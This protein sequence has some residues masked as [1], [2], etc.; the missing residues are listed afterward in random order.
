MTAYSRCSKTTSDG[1]YIL[2]LHSVNRKIMDFAIYLPKDLLRFD[3]DLRKWLA[4]DLERGQITV[5]L[6]VQHENINS[7]SNYILQLR[8]SKENWE[9]I[10]YELGYNP[11][12]AIDFS[13]VL[14]HF[15]PP[16]YFNQAEEEKIKAFLF[17]L[18]QEGLKQLVKMKRE[19]GKAIEADL[20]NRLKNIEET[21]QKI[22][23]KKEIPIERYRKRILEVLKAYQANSSDLV[24]K[25]SREVAIFAEKMDVAEELMRL[26]THVIHFR[27][28]LIS[29]EKAVGKTLE[30]LIQEMQREI[31]TLGS[32]A[33]DS[34][35]IPLVIYVK[36]ELEKMKEQIQNVE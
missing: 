33:N 25:A 1:S 12:K 17:E 6:L 10:S 16:I 21:L 30:F 36:S 2:E 15:S 23:Q 4:Q 26:E 35:I 28:Y 31:N 32:K 27:N 18:A 13:F 5:R 22:H 8:K 34:E 9:N 11:D 29:S 20:Q 3:V 14:S 7:D 19:E 24:E